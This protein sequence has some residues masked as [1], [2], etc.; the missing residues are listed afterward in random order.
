[1][2]VAF[3]TDGWTARTVSAANAVLAWIACIAHLYA[4]SSTSGA[5]RKMFMTI[6]TLA[7]FYSF[8]YWWLFLNPLRVNEW[9]DFLRPFG[10]V[11][12]VMAW[13]VEPI[14][15]VSYLERSGRRL[16]RA[17]QEAAE[18]AKQRLDKFEE[19]S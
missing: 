8:A 15:L 7:L 14:V 5:I 4:A 2:I 9:S 19:T 6:G 16:Q 10:I 13:A 1:V 18:P 3:L 12:W 17:A 11:T